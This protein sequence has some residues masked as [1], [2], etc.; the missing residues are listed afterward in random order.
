MNESI[1]TIENHLTDISIKIGSVAEKNSQYTHG[2]A[3]K[4]SK[5]DKPL[6]QLTLNELAGQIDQHTKG[7]NAIFGGES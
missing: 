6:G 3:L 4:L 2:L 7:F 5:L 1:E